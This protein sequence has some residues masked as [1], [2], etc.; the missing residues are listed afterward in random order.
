MRSTSVIWAT[1]G[2]PSAPASVRYTRHA[3][4]GTAPSAANGSTPFTKIVGDPTNPSRCTSANVPTGTVVTVTATPAS[5]AASRTRVIASCQFG[6]PEKNWMVTSTSRTS[7]SSPT[8]RSA[9]TGPQ[10]RDAGRGRVSAAPRNVKTA[11]GTRCRRTEGRD[12]CAW[13]T[14][15]V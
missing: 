6:Q 11:S 14:R 5:R 2:A 4:A 10:P 9:S 13:T 3:S 8:P 12:E 7:P 1:V 15:P